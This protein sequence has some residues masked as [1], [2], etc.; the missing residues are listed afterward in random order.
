MT[1]LVKC[2]F[3]DRRFL[4]D[5]GELETWYSRCECGASGFVLD[6]NELLVHG[7]CG[8]GFS[9]QEVTT[10]F[11]TRILLADPI[12]IFVDSLGNKFFV[13]WCRP[14][15]DPAVVIC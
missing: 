10:T 5:P 7:F 13:C 1:L 11:G 3:C 4:L 14:I 6:E 8:A 9:V 2:A 15:D 12:S